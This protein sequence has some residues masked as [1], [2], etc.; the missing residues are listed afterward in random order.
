MLLIAWTISL[1]LRCYS[2][3]VYIKVKVA[4]TVWVLEAIPT[5]SGTKLLNKSF[6]FVKLPPFMLSKVHG[7]SCTNLCL[8]HG[9]STMF[10][11]I[12]CKNLGHTL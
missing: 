5:K 6:K 10:T 2:L 4:Q 3:L 12:I 8:V 11:S 7:D 1:P 9:L